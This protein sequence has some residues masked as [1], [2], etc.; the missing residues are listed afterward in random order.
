MSEAIRVVCRFRRD[1]E[2][3]EIDDWKFDHDIKQISLGEKKY[4]FDEIMDMN[5][6]QV[7]MY[8][9]VALKTIENFCN[10]F[11]GTIVNRI[12]LVRVWKFRIWKNLLYRRPRRNRRMASQG[13][14]ISSREHPTPLRYNPKTDNLSV[15]CNQ[16]CSEQ[17]RNSR[18]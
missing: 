12:N 13:F 17:R 3:K 14:L 7:E 4:N 6:D 5:C 9:K 10:G 15:F 11:H 8:E 1:A 2:G 16:R 18:A